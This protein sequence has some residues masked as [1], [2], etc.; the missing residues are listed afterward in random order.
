MTGDF[1]FYLLAFWIF[2]VIG[3]YTAI[4]LVKSRT[5]YNLT[6]LIIDIILLILTVLSYFYL[7]KLLHGVH[8]LIKFILV[9]I[10]LIPL[11]IFLFY[12]EI[13]KIFKRRI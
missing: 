11:I 3:I 6:L 1:W 7:D 4:V 13:K 9:G 8:S 5:K 2:L 10:V 12:P